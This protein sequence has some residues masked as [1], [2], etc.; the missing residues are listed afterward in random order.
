MPPL[1]QE[2]SMKRQQR[3]PTNSCAESVLGLSV[4]L[5]ALLM[6]SSMRWACVSAAR[7][8]SPEHRYRVCRRATCRPNNTSWVVAGC[9]RKLSRSLAMMFSTVPVVELRNF[10]IYDQRVLS[11]Y[12]S[13][14]QQQRNPRF[15]V[16]FCMP[17][18]RID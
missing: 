1:T 18:F 2:F 10:K 16:T 15:Q 3:E 4:L 6:A 11:R 12:C 8:A 5:K 14:L 7:W 17:R 9:F 13:A